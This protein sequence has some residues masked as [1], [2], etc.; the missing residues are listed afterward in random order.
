MNIC[1]FIESLLRNVTVMLRISIKCI[2]RDVL[3][4]V[5]PGYLLNALPEEAPEHPEEWKKVIKDFNQNIMPGVSIIY[6]K[7]FLISIYKK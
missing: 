7:K 4:S 2:F 1:V 5:E 6:K 3:P